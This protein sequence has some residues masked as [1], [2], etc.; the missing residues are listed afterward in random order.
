MPTS[1]RF[2]VKHDFLKLYIQAIIE[3]IE[4]HILSWN[5]LFILKVLNCLTNSYQLLTLYKNH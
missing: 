2:L 4:T 1:S 3:I 5:T